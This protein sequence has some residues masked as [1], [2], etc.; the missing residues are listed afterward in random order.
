MYT[1][2]LKDFVKNLESGIVLNL[3]KGLC[4]INIVY[5]NLQR[6]KL[7]TEQTSYTGIRENLS[8]M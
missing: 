2:K 3:Y 8:V 1:E 6:E 4:K 7:T 5:F